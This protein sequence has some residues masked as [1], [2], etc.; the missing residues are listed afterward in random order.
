VWTTGFGTFLLMLIVQGIGLVPCVGW[1]LPFLLGV[2]GIGAVVLAFFD[3]RRNLPIVAAP[4]AG[5]DEPLPQ[6]S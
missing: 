1:L 3:A 2:V 6:A 5:P 4:A